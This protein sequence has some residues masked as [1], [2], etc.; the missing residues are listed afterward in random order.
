MVGGIVVDES[1]E[2]VRGQRVPQSKMPERLYRLGDYAILA[3]SVRDIGGEIDH[4]PKDVVIGNHV[5]WRRDKLGIYELH[6]KPANEPAQYFYVGDLQIYSPPY[7]EFTQ[8][9]RKSLES[10]IKLGRLVPAHQGYLNHKLKG[11]EGERFYTKEDALSH[12]RYN[13]ERRDTRIIIP[14]LN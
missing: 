6:E 9:E 4:I 5:E 3:Y 12:C 14:R 8:W 1:F 7:N 11:F 10:E 13:L 2:R